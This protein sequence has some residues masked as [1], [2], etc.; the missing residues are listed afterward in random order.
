MIN[1]ETE[2][3]KGEAGMSVIQAACLDFCVELLN[4]EI[5]FTEYES[6][7]VCALAVLGVSETGW[8]GPDTYP[9]ILSAVIKCA[10]F[11]VVQKAVRIAGSLVKNEY[12]AGRRK[13]VLEEDSG[14]DTG[15]T[16]SPSLSPRLRSRRERY[17]SSPIGVG[18]LSPNR[19]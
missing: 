14:Y 10:R 13:M 9:P 17:P 16:A 5:E 12:F 8:R 7:L 18:P 4:I 19:F 6:A 3:S 1:S 11:M 15:D 2:P